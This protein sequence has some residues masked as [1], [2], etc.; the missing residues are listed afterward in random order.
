MSVTK[1]INSGQDEASPEHM[2][3]LCCPIAILCVWTKNSLCYM[4]DDII[5][6][7]K[8]SYQNVSSLTKKELRRVEYSLQNSVIY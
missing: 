3:K 2:P 5:L 1:Y 8:R 6:L 7:V 4:Q